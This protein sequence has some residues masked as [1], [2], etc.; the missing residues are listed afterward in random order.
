MASAYDEALAEA[1]ADEEGELSKRLLAGE[2]NDDD[3]RAARE[4]LD[5]LALRRFELAHPVAPQETATEVDLGEVELD[6][7]KKAVKDAAAENEGREVVIR[8]A[9]RV[10]PD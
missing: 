9:V 7:V 3:R 8:L 6:D 5:E 2:A 1:L 10:T 4:Q